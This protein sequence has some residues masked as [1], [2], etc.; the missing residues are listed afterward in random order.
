MLGAMLLG[1]GLALTPIMILLIN[2]VGDGI[3][4]LR[5]AYETSDPRIM[6]RKPIGRNESFFSG[7]Q[8]VIAKQTIAFVTVSM[9]VFWIGQNVQLMPGYE[10]SLVLA[11]TMVFLTVGFCSILHVLTVR[12]R[13]SIF[14]RTIKDNPQLLM[15]VIAMIVLF[16]LLIVIT[17]VANALGMVSIGSRHWLLV[18]GLSIIPTIVAE[19]GKLIQNGLETRRYQR[20]L[21]HHTLPLE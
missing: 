5:L 2:V 6:Q 17:P 13:V 7:I 18:A 9:T 3:P 19:I 14:K 12:S 8:Y 20:R 16:I 4:G 10:P 1:W 11:Q 21:V 15:L